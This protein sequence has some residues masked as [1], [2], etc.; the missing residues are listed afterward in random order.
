MTY[1]IRAIRA[2]GLAAALLASLGLQG[3][4]SRPHQQPAD[5]ILLGGAIL[6]MDE[7]QPTAEAVAIRDSRIVAVGSAR[8]VL[9]LRGPHTEVTRLA[10][11]ALLPGFFQAHAHFYGIAAKSDVVNLDPPPIGEVSSIAEI[12]KRVRAEIEKSAGV[13]PTFIAG[14]GYDDTLLAEKRHPTRDDLDAVS[15]D[16]PIFLSHISGHLAV[17]NSKALEMAGIDASTPDPQGGH[18]RRR[19]GS[20]EPDGVLEETA[21]AKVAVH[22]PQPSQDAFNRA[23]ARTAEHLASLGITTAVEHAA[24]P[25]IVAAMR[26]FADTGQLQLDL[27]AF[28]HI[29]YGEAAFAGFS[30]TYRNG[31]RVGGIKLT[32]DGSIQGYTGYLTEPYFRQAPNR[33][34]DY[35]GYPTMPAQVVETAITRLYRERIPFAAHTNGDAAIDLLIA[36]VRKAQALH[37]QPDLR[38]TVIHAQTMREDQLDAATELGLV[39]SFFVDH[40]Y[41]WGDRHRDIFLGPKRASRISPAAS[42]LSRGLRFTLHDDAPVVPPH[43]LLTVWA[44]VN[45]ITASGQI[46]GAEQR[47]GVLDAL[48]AVTRE[49]AYQHHEE[50]DKGSITV[51]KRADL[52]IL[53][54]D[55][56]AVALAALRDLTVIETIKDGRSIFALAGRPPAV[57]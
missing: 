11:R 34:A 32:L 52:V 49:P 38:P 12:Q 3:C 30:P 48:K 16:V 50:R 20:S 15:R 53:S 33:P 14:A 19:P 28:P 25:P 46:L 17:A 13:P 51:G 44:A 55:P 42:A 47:I 37:P 23:F 6:T 54:A 43:P 21:M 5:R 4:A 57:R 29:S 10:D 36:A 31:F 22:F 45:R 56:R 9:R 26:A 27:V 24:P 18:I 35:C 8:T 40:V 7:A 2:A 39:P 41:Y 1:R